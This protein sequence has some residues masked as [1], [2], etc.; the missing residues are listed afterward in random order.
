VTPGD[1]VNT[2]SPAACSLTCLA[3][4]LIIFFCRF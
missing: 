3:F 2:F 1:D 4:L